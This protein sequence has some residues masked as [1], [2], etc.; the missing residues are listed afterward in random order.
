MPS[1]VHVIRSSYAPALG[2][3]CSFD[4]V[5]GLHYRRSK[6]VLRVD[7]QHIK[8]VFRLPKISLKRV[9]KNLNLL[10][11]QKTNQLLKELIDCIIPS[12]I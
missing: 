5:P 2:Q 4:V 1:L 3:N 11:K 8:F 12:M 6:T 10:L 7:E 9:A